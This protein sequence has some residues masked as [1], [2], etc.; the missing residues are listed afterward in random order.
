[1]IL[2]CKSTNYYTESQILWF[3]LTIKIMGISIRSTEIAKKIKISIF[4]LNLIK[5]SNEKG[6]F[7]FIFIDF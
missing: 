2:D 7:D 4:R 1:M 6:N 5:S 3:I